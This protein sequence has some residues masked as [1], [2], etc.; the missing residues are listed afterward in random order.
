LAVEVLERRELLSASVEPV[1]AAAGAGPRFVHDTVLR[2]IVYEDVDGHQEALDVYEPDGPA[3]PGGRPTIVAIHGGGWRRFSKSEYGP[4]VAAQFTPAGYVVVA[5]DYQ[6]SAPGAPSWP[7]SVDD[8][9]N[10]V[11]WVRQ[12]ASEFDIDPERLVALGESAGGQLAALLATNPDGPPEGGTI[13][14]PPAPGETSARVAA[15]IDFYGPA[16]LAALAAESPVAAIAASQFLGGTPAEIP[17][18]YSAASPV[19]H[20]APGDPPMLLLHGA[21]DHLVPIDQAQELSQTLSA[22]GVPNQLVT[23]PAAH[24]GFEFQPQG[25][26]LVPELLAFLNATWKD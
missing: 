22:A 11:R 2:D 6:L 17:Q 1:E 9:R 10:A 16:D 23:V 4:Q 26:K 20:V 14:S 5:I 15:V 8:V 7:T 25:L 24:H 12:H 19:D 3:P 21:N 13:A 18:L